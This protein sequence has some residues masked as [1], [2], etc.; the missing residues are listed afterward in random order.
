LIALL[1]LCSAQTY[2]GYYQWTWNPPGNSPSGTNIGIAFNGWS[3]PGSAVGDSAP[4][5]GGLLGTK[6]IALGGGNTDGY[7]TVAQINAVNNAIAANTFSGYAGLCYDIEE[8]DSGL[9]NAFEQSFAIAKGAGLKVLVTISH[10]GPYGIP[11]AITVMNNIF[12]STNVDFVSPQ[13]YAS[14]TETTNDYTTSGG[15][16]AVPWSS[17]EN[18][19][20][21]IL[22]SITTSTLW[23]CG[24]TYF[25]TTLGFPTSKVQGYI[26]WNNDSPSGISDSCTGGSGGTSLTT[27]CGSDWS[28][29][30]GRCG[31]AC[32]IDSDCTNDG[33]H[34]YASL[35]PITGCNAAIEETSAITLNHMG[36]TPTVIGLSVALVVIALALIVVSVFLYKKSVVRRAEIA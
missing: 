22:L 16:G 30:N 35:S 11:D 9:A 13:L 6:Y 10:S 5:I 36:M 3:N 15:G 7:W 12:A 31:G 27:R 23:N 34:C 24:N 32:Q 1:S 20:A 18:A 28:N 19:Q 2:I 25:T 17:W 29:A 4:V 14:G 33:G 26:V 8:G 21:G